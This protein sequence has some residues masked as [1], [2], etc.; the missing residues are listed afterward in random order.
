MPELP[1]VE[2]IR[3]GLVPVLENARIRSVQL[4]RPDLRFPFPQN[5]EKNLT[6]KRILHLS[7]RAKYLLWHLEDGGVLVIHL[8]MSGSIRIQA[9]GVS[10]RSTRQTGRTK[11]SVHDHVIFH[12]HDG[13]TLIYNDPRRFGYMNI[14]NGSDWTDHP[15]FADLGPEPTGNDLSA[16]HL[17]SVFA[18]RKTPAKTILLDQKVIAGMGNIYVCEALWR[19]RISP[20]RLARTLV[21][22][23][24]RPTVALERLLGAIRTIIAEAI[25]AGGSSISDYTLADGSMGRFQ[26]TFSAYGQEGCPCARP[27][28]SGSIRRIVQSGRSTFYCPRC[29]R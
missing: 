24:G 2:T 12:L 14:V 3:R 21:R 29:Q 9:P 10:E 23:D 5:F 18:D 17:A 20:R 11:R 8:G 28:C 22:K 15:W 16:S 7:R 19:A 1:E 26:H 6:G 4:R 27:T 25:D 13:H